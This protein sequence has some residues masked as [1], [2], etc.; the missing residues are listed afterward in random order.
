MNL[1]VASSSQHVQR[2]QTIQVH[3]LSRF[4][5]DFSFHSLFRHNPFLFKQKG[6]TVASG[7]QGQSLAVFPES[8]IVIA[9]FGLTSVESD[10]DLSSLLEDVMKSVI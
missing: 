5:I 2:R 9:R 10:W 8:D 7:Y 3:K 6:M 1:Q 4:V